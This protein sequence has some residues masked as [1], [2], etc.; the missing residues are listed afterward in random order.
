MELKEVCIFVFHLRLNQNLNDKEDTYFK[1]IILWIFNQVNINHSDAFYISGGSGNQTQSQTICTADGCGQ[2]SGIIVGTIIGS[3]FALAVTIFV[4][5]FV[6]NR[7][8]GRAFRSNSRFVKS[9]KSKSLKQE[10]DDFNPFQSG[11]WTSR[12]FVQK[13]WKD[14][15]PLSLSFDSQSTKVTGS[16]TDYIGTFTIDGVYSVKT[17][18]MGLTK[19]YAVGTSNSLQ[20]LG[21]ISTYQVT[22]NSESQQFEGKWY[23][24]TVKCKDEG[25]FELKFG[26][27]QQQEQQQQ[28]QFQYERL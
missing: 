28:E 10:P 24:H 26:E 27:H 8:R 4:S 11:N 15:H 3:L 14:R 9:S 7:C 25:K 5:S 21:H 18:R 23:V 17:R 6:Y 12:R 2:A 19:Q 16:G 1:I 20:N 13:K 22:W